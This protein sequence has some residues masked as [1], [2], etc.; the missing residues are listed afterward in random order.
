VVLREIFALLLRIYALLFLINIL[1]NSKQT[2]KG[3][4]M[5]RPEMSFRKNIQLS[6]VD[7][8]KAKDFAERAN[9]KVGKLVDQVFGPSDL[10]VT[11]QQEANGNYQYR[12]E[13]ETFSGFFELV[14]GWDMQMSGKISTK[15]MA[16]NSSGDA[17]NKGYKK[18]KKTLEALPDY[19]YYG[20]MLTGAIAGFT[21]S[22]LYAME[23]ESL[24]ATSYAV[25]TIIIGWIGSMVGKFIAG[26][27][28]NKRFDSVN[29][30]A[31]EDQAFLRSASKWLTFDNEVNDLMDWLLQEDKS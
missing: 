16:L 1:Y 31:M 18:S 14:V 21:A 22:M 3:R 17:G 26:K 15:F 9:E 24:D 30:K 12:M 19:G 7:L 11:Y 5:I 10:N 4:F 2:K 20:G 8:D 29:V 25:F 23:T 6:I 13:N 27:V 28:Y